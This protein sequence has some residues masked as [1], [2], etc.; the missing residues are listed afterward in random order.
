MYY[1]GLSP[2][3]RQARREYLARVGD[4][5]DQCKR[6]REW[7]RNRWPHTNPPRIV[8]D[9]VPLPARPAERCACGRRFYGLCS[10]C[11]VPGFGF[12]RPREE[13][14]AAALRWATGEVGRQAVQ[15]WAEGRQPAQLRPRL[16]IPLTPAEDPA[17]VPLHSETEKE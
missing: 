4:V 10:A 5:S 6:I 15:D 9:L 11:H 17:T 12:R 1:H 16:K 13:R 8:P 2:A 3:E 7:S 14:L